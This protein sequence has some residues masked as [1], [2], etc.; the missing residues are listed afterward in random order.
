MFFYNDPI[1]NLINNDILSACLKIFVA[2]VFGAITGCER[3]NKR[4]SAGLRTF[5]LVILTS[6]VS[7][8][9]DE[10]I[11]IN[12]DVKLPLL[13]AATIISSIMLSGNSILFSSK[14]QIKGL[15]TS[16]ALWF[17][18]LIGLVIG[19]GLYILSFILFII[20]LL[21]LSILPSLESLLKNHSNHFEVHLELNNK[22]YLQNFVTTIR[23]LG[24]VIDDIELNNAYIGSGLSV[25]TISISIINKKEFKNY[26]EIIKALSCLDY[27][28]Y[29]EELK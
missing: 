26:K 6:C 23:E 17:C 27:I 2:I 18:C 20:L 1:N 9:L 11:I 22:T 3:S 14:K 16:A 7:M 4:H 8:I 13:S 19:K 24:L 12:S 25:Y 29:I 28:H 21:T 10:A 15:T 5:I